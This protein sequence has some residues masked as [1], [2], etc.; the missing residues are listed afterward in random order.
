MVAILYRNENEVAASGADILGY[1]ENSPDGDSSWTC[2]A[3]RLLKLYPPLCWREVNRWGVPSRV[4]P[5]AE[6]WDCPPVKLGRASD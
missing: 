4:H 3:L 2:I 5:P 1:A 6:T